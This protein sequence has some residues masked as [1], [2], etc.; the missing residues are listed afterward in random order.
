MISWLQKDLDQH[1]AEWLIVFFH[2]PPYTKGT[3]DSDSKFDSGGRMID[4][5]ENILPILETYGVDL[6]LA[7]HSHVY[8]R[9]HLIQKHYGF[10]ES[11][12]EDSMIVSRGTK[13]K[14]THHYMKQNEGSGTMYIVCGI[15]CHKPS[16][17][18]LHHPAMFYGSDLHVGSL[19]I[20]VQG[21]VLNGRLINSKGKIKDH[22]I[23]TK[24]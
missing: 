1:P 24:Q 3:H 19:S 14:G 17:A 16:H 6:V 11:F 8:E 23:I 7:G 10:S 22:F 15:G 13:K 9:S 21:N 20:E 18:P 2:H 12:E 4:V 5:R